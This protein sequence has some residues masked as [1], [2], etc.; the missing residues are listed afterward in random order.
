M[1]NDKN[2]K[3]SGIG[4]NWRNVGIFGGLIIVTIVGLFFLLSRQPT[5]D[6]PKL[7][8]PGEIMADIQIEELEI[9]DGQEVV[10]G[11]TVS[12][13]YTGTLVNGTKFDSSLDHGEPFEFSVGEGQVIQ[14]WDI[15]LVGMKVGGKRKLTIPPELGYGEQGA[16]A[17]I[18]PNSTLVFEIELLEVKE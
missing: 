11:N 6:T 14:G 10:E 16:G 12:V 1:T 13:H 8:I 5:V 2:D 17:S 3:D 18:P 9:G 7:E 4:F 15:G